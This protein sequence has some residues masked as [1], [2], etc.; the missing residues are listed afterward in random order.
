MRSGHVLAYACL[1]GC[2]FSPS[3]TPG[4][5]APPD[6]G[7]CLSAPTSEC[8]DDLTLRSCITAGLPPTDTPCPWGC[9]DG[10]DAHCGIVNPFGGGATPADTDPETFDALGTIVLG[11][12]TT[13]NGTA[14]TI[15]G[16]TTGFEYAPRGTIGVFRFKSLTIDAPVRL[17]GTRAIV[18]IA[19]GPIVVSALI[20]ARGDCTF[21]NGATAPGPGGF[22]GGTAAV[23]N[24]LGPGGG[25][26]G[27]GQSGGG[28]G[29]HGGVGGQGGPIPLGAQGGAGGVVNGTAQITLLVGGS[30]G[31]A[32]AGAGGHA[33]GGGGGGAIQLVSNTRIVFAPGGAIDAGGCGGDS[34]KGGGEDGGGGGGAGGTILLEAPLI[35]G[36]GALAVNGGGGGAGDDSDIPETRPTGFGEAGRLDRV[37]AA[38]AVGSPTGAGGGNGA[39]AASYDGEEGISSPDHAG[40]GGGAVGR[41]RF[42][43]RLGITTV[44]VTGEMSPALGDPGS[45]CTAGTARVQ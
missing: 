7:P 5:A 29:G 36:T 33:R 28:G 4:D 1:V 26:V 12:P 9:K 16:V 45:T 30:G 15:S 14:G 3:G 42:N 19:D 22:A 10:A 23:D 39:A 13:I 27:T 38:G 31:G 44:T 32:T 17:T 20:D 21:D 43:T 25:V 40:G 41:I 37:P 35:E 6:A 24:G 18:L 8:A 2:K 11:G 34:G